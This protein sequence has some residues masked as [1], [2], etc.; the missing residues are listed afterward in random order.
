[1]LVL[2]TSSSGANNTR[3]SRK[4]KAD[5]SFIGELNE[6]SMRPIRF[7]RLSNNCRE[8]VSLFFLCREF[9]HFRHF[10]DNVDLMPTASKCDAEIA[11]AESLFAK[12]KMT[13]E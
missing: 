1:M 3:M 9:A 5:C 12:V 8:I 13:N 10:D 7:Q 6:S 11:R 2:H 4:L